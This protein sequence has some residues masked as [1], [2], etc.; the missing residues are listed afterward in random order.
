MITKS[1]QM[2]VKMFDNI[3][4]ASKLQS[5]QIT[6][7]KEW[8]DVQVLFHEIENEYNDS[9]G[10]DLFSDL[11]LFSTNMPASFNQISIY[12]DKYR[13]GQVFSQLIENSRKFTKEGNIDVGVKVDSN[14]V[15]F[16]IE[17][18]GSGIDKIRNKEVYNLFESTESTF[19]FES[20]GSGLGLGIAKEMCTQ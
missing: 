2:L 9:R 15:T 6:F 19:T 10:D 11:V 7:R 16:Y 1:S 18:S 17:D 3:I 20:G 8:V 12:T 14:E 4:D 13:L 5:H